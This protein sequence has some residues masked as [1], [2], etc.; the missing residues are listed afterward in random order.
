MLQNLSQLLSVDEWLTYISQIHHQAMDFGLD[1]IQSVVV[2]LHWQKFS[3]PVVIVGGTNGKGSCVRFLESIFTAAGYRVGAYTSPHLMSF[4]ERIRVANSVV[5]DTTLINAF[6]AVEQNRQTVSLSFFEFT[7]LAALQIFQKASLDLVILEVGLGGRLDAVNIVDADIA[8]ITTLDL[9]HMDLLGPDRESIANEKAGI[10]RAGRA[11][12]CGDP[13]PPVNL[14]QRARDI[15][16]HWYAIG[17]SFSFHCTAQTTAWQWQGIER[18]YEQLPALSLKH[19]NAATSLMVVELL[20]DRLPVAGTPLRQGLAWATLAGRF[21]KVHIH[22]DYYAYVDVAHN[23]Q[24]ARWLAEQWRQVPVRGKRMAIFAMLG[25]KD[26]AGTLHSL[27]HYVDSWYVA[28][29]PVPRGATAEHCY[30]TLVAQGARCC[31][32]F[33]TVEHALQAAVA[34]ANLERDAILVFG[35][36]YTVAAAR[37]YLLLRRGL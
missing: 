26:I 27:L 12:V 7:F 31:H 25:D 14:Q 23:P 13:E 24:G 5:D 19:Q 29:L 37:H 1:R 9:D 17:E 3:C 6:E 2:P 34:D 22:S 11:V 30:A 28:T 15:G 20:Q 21:E 4:N 18:H 10:F 36:F 35:S 32:L 33:S 16:A 8:V